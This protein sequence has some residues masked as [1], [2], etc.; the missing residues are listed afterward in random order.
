M[1]KTPVNLVRVAFGWFVCAAPS[2]MAQ[3]FAVNWFTVDGGGGM[4][5]TGGGYSLGGTIAQPDAGTMSGSRFA[6]SGGFWPGAD[7]GCVGTERVAK[8][9][10]KDRNGANQLKV[11]LAGGR[12]GDTFTVTLTD[13]SSSS[14]TVNR[15]GKGKAKFNNRPPADSGDATASWGCGASDAKSYSCP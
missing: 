13:D 2:V 9:T 4:F 7:N 5:S 3:E 8:T 11:I 15:R 1:K 6:V 10:C 12:E 14:G